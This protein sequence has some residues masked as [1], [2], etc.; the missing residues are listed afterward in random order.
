MNKD[1]L[2]KWIDNPWKI[3]ISFA[4]RGWLNFLPDKAYLS[5]LYR[6]NFK[7][8]IDWKNPKTFNEK[9]QWLKLIDRNI[10]YCDMVDKYKVK[11]DV[12][13]KIG[14]EHVVPIL[15][16][17]W[18]NFDEID[19][20]TLPDQFVLKTTHD[21]GGVFICKDKKSIDYQKAKCF[22]EKHLRRNYYF[23]CRE[24]PYKNIIPRIFAERFISDKENTVLPVYKIFCFDGCPKIIQ[25][26]LNDK[27]INESVD[28]F[29][30][31]WNRLNLKQNFP[32]ST[33]PLMRP[34]N[35][36]TMLRIAETLSLGHAF[37]RVDLYEANGTIYFSEYTF[38]SD[39]GFAKFEPEEW[40]EILGSW[41][42]LPKTTQ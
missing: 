11:Q 16:G 21:C 28:Y 34:H 1:T 18:N 29:D 31:Q 39:A 14:K 15:G 3:G 24:W 27:Q 6:A 8:K 41:I 36:D 30:I 22:L 37:I 12:S 26:I 20:D 32:N 13:S 23:H 7:K 25:V 38:Y 4:R 17:P 40:D 2:R 5:I 33:Q 10:N 9:L 35:L 19:F 42:Q